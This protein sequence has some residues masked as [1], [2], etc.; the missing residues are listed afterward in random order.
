MP[1]IFALVSRKYLS[2]LRSRSAARCKMSREL[3]PWSD[4][5]AVRSETSSSVTSSPDALRDSQRSVGSAAVMRNVRSSSTEIVPSSI[6]LPSWSHQGV[7]ST[8]PT[9]AFATLRVTTWSS[10]RAA[11]LPVI[12]YLNSGET[13]NNAAELRIAWYSRSCDSS[14]DDATTYPAQRR[15]ACP[16]DNGPVGAGNGVVLRL[17]RREDFRPAR[18]RRGPAA[19]S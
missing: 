10:S 2:A 15:Q 3:G 16:S 1:R 19:R 5:A 17:T 18:R 11:S 12:R 4:S 9:F 14:Y 6:C 13:S 8:C 7:Y